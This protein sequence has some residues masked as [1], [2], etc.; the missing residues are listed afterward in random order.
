MAT[1]PAP[2]TRAREETIEADSFAR[3]QRLRRRHSELYR[4]ISKGLDYE[5][6]DE[7]Y[8]KL[9]SNKA[10]DHLN[11]SKISRHNVE[12]FLQFS[13]FTI[14]KQIALLTHNCTGRD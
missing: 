14:G 10:L 11:F 5:S 9:L 3:C 12:E 1:V 2:P 8:N 6:D 13:F 7:G 4:E